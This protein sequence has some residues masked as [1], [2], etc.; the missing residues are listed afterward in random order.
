MPKDT[1]NHTSCI[2]YYQSEKTN[3]QSSLFPNLPCRRSKAYCL[4][5]DD[6]CYL[7]VTASGDTL[8]P[9][10]FRHS[11]P[12]PVWPM[13]QP[14]RT[15]GGCPAIHHSYTSNELCRLRHILPDAIQLYFIHC[16]LR[17]VFPLNVRKHF[18]GAT[19]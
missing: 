17:R 10:H 16:N 2:F 18:G 14:V 11:P 12:S 3:L 19:N 7:T 4:Q 8:T 15:S 5:S 6:N 1:F 9:K 13:P